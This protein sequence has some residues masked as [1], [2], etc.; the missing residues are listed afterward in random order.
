MLNRPAFT[1]LRPQNSDFK[2]KGILENS[3][4]KFWVFINFHGL[5]SK[6]KENRPTL[7]SFKY[8]IK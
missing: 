6:K 2:K 1:A 5:F 8:L 7:F 4:F 3:G